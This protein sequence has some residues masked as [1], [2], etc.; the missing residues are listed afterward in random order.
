MTGF[1]LLLGFVVGQRLVELA[2][3]KSNEKSLKS[4]GAVEAGQE[5]YRW[6]VLLHVAFFLSFIV[7]VVVYDVRPADWYWLPLSL[8][9][10][11]QILRVWA[12]VSLGRFWNTKIIILPDANVVSRG[13]YRFLK[14]PNYLVVAVEIIALPLIFQAYVTAVVF[15]VLNAILILGVRIPAEEKALSQWTDYGN[16]FG[17]KKV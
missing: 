7:E 12:L 1:Y 13:P 8:F 11:A 6:I 4:R 17:R 15:T 9:V 5:H 10:V 2:I 16:S 14:H 3:A